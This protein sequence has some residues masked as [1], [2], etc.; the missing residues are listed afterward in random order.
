M[1]AAS[2]W[3]IGHELRRRWAGVLA[4]ALIV[5]LGAGGSFVAL[6]AAHRTAGAYASY[7]DRARV[8]DVVINPSLGN[9]AS[10]RLIR[11]LPGVRTVRRDVLLDASMDDGH[12]RTRA[13]LDADPQA[14][15]VRGSTEGRF[16]D[17][18]RLA[19]VA[20]RAPTGRR[21]AVLT[22]ELATARGVHVGDVVPVA[23]WDSNDDG[24]APLDTQMTPVGVEHLRV[25]GIGTMADEVLPDRL[26][27]RGRL[28]VSRD[29]VARYDCLPDPPPA[30]ATLEQAQDIVVPPGCATS[31]PYYSLDLADATAGVAPVLDAFSARADELNRQ[32]PPAMLEQDLGYALVATSTAQERARVERSLDPIVITLSVLALGAGVVAL[33]LAGLVVARALRR[34]EADQRQ[35]WRLGLP[36][37]ARTSV[38]AAPHLIALAIGLAGALVLAWVASPVAP[39]G[40]VRSID[41]SPGRVLSGW[42]LAA[43]VAVTVLGTIAVVGLSARTVRRL[44]P[45]QRFRS[46]RSGLGRFLRSSSSSSALRGGPRRVRQ[47]RA[48]AWSSPPER[49]PPGCSWRPSCSGPACRRWCRRQGPTA[50]PGTPR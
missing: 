23:F 7:L 50:G 21:E 35:L 13:V 4:L 40:A 32:L 28:I 36:T 6:A 10:D 24:F 19:Y 38:V 26:Y 41:P 16:I 20:G 17:A 14:I 39:V 34:A 31:Y 8:G 1:T 44:A 27:P 22:K 45:E 49:W 29:I 46:P 25:V 48:R 47:S 37:R 5:T 43:A 30:D 11:H 15:Q 18:D 42:V 3:L 12:P 33:V 9:T 2:R